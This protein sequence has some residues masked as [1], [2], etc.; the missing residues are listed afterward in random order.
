MTTRPIDQQL[1]DMLRCPLTLSPLTRDGDELVAAV[2][3]LRYPIRDGIPV[4]LPE[5]AKL[6]EGVA[7]LEEFKK[8]FGRR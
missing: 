6:P 1:V 5:E 7:T 3:G 4:M 2:G 8:R